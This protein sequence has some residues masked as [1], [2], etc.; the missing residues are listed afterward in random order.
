[1][2]SYVEHIKKEL[3]LSNSNFPDL[4]KT[5]N[6]IAQ[7]LKQEAFCNWLSA[8]MNGYKDSKCANPEYR[9]VRGDLVGWT[10]TGW[11]PVTGIYKSQAQIE[12]YNRM[13]I[14]NPI[15]VI[16]DWAQSNEKLTAL[17]L[18]YEGIEMLCRIKGV[19]TN[20]AFGILNHEFRNIISIVE[21]QII[22][23]IIKLEKAGIVGENERFS[24]DEIEK[25]QNVT[26]NFNF[27]E[28]VCDSQ[29]NINSSNVKQ[30]KN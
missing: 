22:D 23:W 5:I 9:I 28:A 14:G 11:V 1:M 15:V 10:D 17:E 24:I 13:F 12:Y 8:E 3:L 7:T 26:I 4:L 21:Q 29:F 30:V 20:F 27:K 16:H 2:N 19:N 18:P 25:A 6:Y